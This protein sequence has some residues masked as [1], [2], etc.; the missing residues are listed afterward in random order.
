MWVLGIDTLIGQVHRH[1]L[2]ITGH[3]A[4]EERSHMHNATGIR[5]AL[6]HTQKRF[7]RAGGGSVQP[8]VLVQRA[9]HG[10]SDEAGGPHALGR[11]LLLVAAAGGQRAHRAVVEH[12]LAKETA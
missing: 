7:A 4:H 2:I 1:S 6:K 12:R 9:A 3:T 5:E 8:L 10:F 11:R